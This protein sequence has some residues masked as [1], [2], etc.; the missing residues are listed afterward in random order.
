MDQT[1]TKGS[2]LRIWVAIFLF[3]IMILFQGSLSFFVVGD[4]GQPDWDF[5][6]IKDLPGES[7]YAVY[8]LNNPQH[9]R[10]SEE[11]IRIPGRFERK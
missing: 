8:Q 5:G 2:A 9:V 7:P 4:L 6:A 1:A 10:G 11:E 3:L